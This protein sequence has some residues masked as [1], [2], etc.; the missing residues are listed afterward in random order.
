MPGAMLTFT[1]AR[2][3]KLEYK[4]I[5]YNHRLQGYKMVT[6]NKKN[7]DE[8]ILKYEHSSMLAKTTKG[9]QA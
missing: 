1:R 6:A 4:K 5:G 8:M 9:E 3:A 2:K 7:N